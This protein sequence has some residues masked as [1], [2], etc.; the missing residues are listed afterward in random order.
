M[1]L[2]AHSLIYATTAASLCFGQS[3]FLLPSNSINPGREVSKNGDM[4]A[5]NRDLSPDFWR[6][7]RFRAIVTAEVDDYTANRNLSGCT[8]LRTETMMKT[9]VRVVS[10]G[11]RGVW[12]GWRQSCCCLDKSQ[13][14]FNR[15]IPVFVVYSTPWSWFRVLPRNLHLRCWWAGG[16]LLVSSNIVT[17]ENDKFH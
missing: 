2:H 15:L 17:I 14:I 4:W 10:T 16:P 9:R 1:N 7:L 6:V 11:F 8:K 13:M 12:R 5:G 3:H